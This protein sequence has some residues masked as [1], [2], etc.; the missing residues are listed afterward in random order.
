MEKKE[1][2][3]DDNEIPLQARMP[4]TDEMKEEQEFGY[5]K[6]EKKFYHRSQ[7]Y[8]NAFEGEF[9]FMNNYTNEGKRNMILSNFVTKERGQAIKMLKTLPMDT[10]IK[11]FCR[12]SR[13]KV[14]HI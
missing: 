3:I 5:S 11:L 1:E 2:T 6:E 9:S 13:N 10:S 14:N 12:G 4:S 8:I 7:A